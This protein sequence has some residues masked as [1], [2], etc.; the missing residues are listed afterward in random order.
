MRKA[1]GVQPT[2]LQK[3]DP[4]ALVIEKIR[5]G[6]RD[7]F[8]IL[9]SRHNQRLF[10]VARSILRSKADAEDVVQQA[11]ILAYTHLDQFA[12]LSTFSTWLTR[13]VI[14]EAT[15]R[16]N[17]TRRKCMSVGVLDEIGIDPAKSPADWMEHQEASSS[18]EMAIDGLAER[19]RMVFIM[20]EVQGLTTTETAHDLGLSEE[21]VKVRLHRA[22]GQ[23][24]SSLSSSFDS[25][26][27]GAFVFLG[28]DCR[29]LHDLVMRQIVL[30]NAASCL[31]TP[32]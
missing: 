8:S 17:Q 15:D 18:L 25:R 22:K 32:T 11:Y 30:I 19:Y 9:V 24:R 1:V 26:E 13:I 4:D 20:R 7:S 28:E 14:R 10:R 21:T 16:L 29:R 6:D 2:N 23:L 5:A 27:P 3:A 12:G 31:E